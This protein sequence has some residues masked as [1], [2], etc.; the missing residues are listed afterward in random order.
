[1]KKIVWLIILFILFFGGFRVMQHYTFTNNAYDDGFN[2]NL[3]WNSLHGKFFYSDIKGY[4]TLG[5]HLEL[6]TLL[7]IPFYLIGLG[8]WILYLGQTLVIALGA[9]PVFWLAREKYGED[10]QFTT[11]FPL[12]YLLYLPTVNIT[13]QGYY[14]IAL[15]ITPL[16]FAAY[17]LIKEKYPP[18]C[19]WLLAAALCQENIYLVAAGFGIY[20]LLFKKSKWLGGALTLAGLVA[21]VGAITYI[22]PA[23]NHA[24]KYEYYQ[25]YAYL[26]QSIPEVINT[27][28]TRPL[29]VLQHVLTGDKILYLIGLLL[30]VAFLPLWN[31]ALLIPCLPILAI[32]L[33]STYRD[34]YQ[35]GTRYPSAII[36]FIFMCAI[37]GYDGAKRS[38]LVR[39]TMVFFMGFS[40]LYFFL[41]FF[42]RYTFITPAVMEGHAALKLI[43]PGASVSALGNIYPHLCHREAIWLFP[44]NWEKAEY[45]VLCRLDPAWPIGGDYAP[46]INKMWQDKNYAK[47]LEYTFIGETPL[48][49]PLSKQEYAPLFHKIMQDKRF[50]LIKNGN[51]YVLLKARGN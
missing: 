22:I 34:M 45:L 19:L 44:K 36:P 21:F 1:M 14:P 7:F 30:P 20:I 13:F 41:A 32:N 10:N 9:L 17:Y 46:S 42:F 27:M 49:G 6:A 12:A 4:V 11:L 43:P 8:P 18:F 31:P 26:G 25:R 2:D 23:F 15:A 33:L 35:L 28:L 24:G 40:L 5:D 48:P 51:Y 37:L 3:V 47:L 16:L 39:K 29:F 50:Q 38:V